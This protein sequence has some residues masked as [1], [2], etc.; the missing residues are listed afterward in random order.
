ML[1]SF[2]VKTCKIL[3]YLIENGQLYKSFHPDSEEEYLSL[4][5]VSKNK[6]KI[7]DTIFTIENGS[8]Y[9]GKSKK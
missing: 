4:K 6:W 7:E 5:H 2:C 8:A 1:K 3:N 9:V